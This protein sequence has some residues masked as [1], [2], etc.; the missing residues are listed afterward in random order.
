MF[1][2]VFINAIPVFAQIK[3]MFKGIAGFKK[4]MGYKQYINEYGNK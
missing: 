2:P 4:G 1:G 3:W